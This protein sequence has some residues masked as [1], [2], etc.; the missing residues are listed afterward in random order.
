[1]RTGE[2]GSPGLAALRVLDFDD[3]GAE[4][5][6]RFGAGGPRLELSQIEHPHAG[7]TIERRAVFSHRYRIL[8][9]P[10]R[11]CTIAQQIRRRKSKPCWGGPPM[12]TNQPSIFIDGESGTTG[13]GIRHRIEMVPGIALRSLPAAQRKDPSSRQDMMAACDLVVLCLPDD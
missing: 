2:G 9:G 6:Q 10:P 13:L 5:G 11:D 8:Q 4:P 7:E 3:F 1:G 12:A